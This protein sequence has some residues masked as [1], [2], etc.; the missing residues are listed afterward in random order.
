LLHTTRYGSVCCVVYAHVGTAAA[1]VVAT[2]AL[3]V[4]VVIATGHDQRYAYT[5]KEEIQGLLHS[6]LFFSYLFRMSNI[7]AQI[8][9]FL[10][11]FAN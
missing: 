1:T 10:S 2:A 5:H 6:N 7:L 3:V 9:A 4:T 11:L 8:Y